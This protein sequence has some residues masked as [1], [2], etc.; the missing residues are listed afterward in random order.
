MEGYKQADNLTIVYLEHL[1]RLGIEIIIS[2]GHVYVK[3]GE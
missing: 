3:E 2:N 1:A